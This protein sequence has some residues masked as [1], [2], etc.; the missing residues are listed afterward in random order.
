MGLIKLQE[1]ELYWSTNP[2]YN[3]TIPSILPRNRYRLLNSAFKLSDLES[4]EKQS[5]TAKKNHIL[6]LKVF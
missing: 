2:L 4:E 1:K 6:K 5:K 3:N